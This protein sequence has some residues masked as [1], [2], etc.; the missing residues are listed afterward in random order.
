MDRI[1]LKW[2]HGEFS[3]FDLE[4]FNMEIPPNEVRFQFARAIMRGHVEVVQYYKDDGGT[5]RPLTYRE[6]IGSKP[7]A[8][9]KGIN[10]P[11]PD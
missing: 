11:E 4:R 2:P 1:T 6:C 8:E 9:E 5:S 3:L 10:L 7:G